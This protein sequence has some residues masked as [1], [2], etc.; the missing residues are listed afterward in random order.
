MRATRSTPG[1]ALAIALALCARAVDSHG[2]NGHSLDGGAPLSWMIDASAP[3]IVGT[4][5]Q[6][7][8]AAPAATPLVSGRGISVTAGEVQ[9]RVR[10]AV[11]LEQ[12]R[13]AAD[14]AALEALVERPIADRPP[15]AVARARGREVRRTCAVGRCEAGG[16]VVGV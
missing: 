6:V 11:E 5:V 10:D 2:Q 1:R 8:A 7:T 12:R 9:E 3:D 14:P 13:Y 4:T 16:A 15:G